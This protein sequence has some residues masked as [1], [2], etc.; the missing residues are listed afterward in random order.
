MLR[1][2]R[3]LSCLRGTVKSCCMTD[4]LQLLVPL[5][6]YKSKPVVAFLQAKYLQHYTC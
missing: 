4:K 2:E 6:F 5:S 3:F 1:G